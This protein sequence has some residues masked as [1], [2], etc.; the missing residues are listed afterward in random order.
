MATAP[1]PRRS[2][3][4]K[5]PRYLPVLELPP[6]PPEQHE[7]LRGNIAL[8]G[9]LVPILV[10]GEGPVRGIID[11]NLRH[12]IAAELG[13]DCPEVVKDGL[14]DQEK[15]T[16]ARALHLARRH[17]DQAGKRAIIADQ[18]R[19]T[20]GRS[21]RWVGKQL[22]VHHATVASVRADLEGTGQ[23]IQLERTVGADGKCRPASRP[24]GQDGEPL[25][26]D[27]PAEP[28]CLLRDGIM[29]SIDGLD[30]E[31]IIR[32]AAEIHRRRATPLDLSAGDARPE[33]KPFFRFSMDRA[34][35][36]ASN[37]RT[38][39]G[40]ARFLH[41]LISPLYSVEVILDPC[42][43]DASL[44]K[45]WKGRTVVDY[46]IERGKDFFD[47]P[48]RI[49][50]DLVLCNPPFNQEPESPSVYR[51][52]QF[53]RR[54]VS[55]VSP[56][57]PI[58][59]IAPMGMRLN[60]NKGSKRWRWLRDGAPSITSIVSLPRDVFSGVDFHCEV[61]LFNMPRLRSHY[62]LPDEYL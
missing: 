13:Y 29:T 19:E 1:R 11:G 44:T 5:S 30:E 33:P 38:P 18:L 61:L 43:G 9:V 54:I 51:P 25:T 41:D 6:L 12:R 50:C 35:P 15:R 17:L 45:P 46:E 2:R 34:R 23:I 4:R 16:L 37:Q 48:P 32:A 39:P 57:K 58:A 60:Q 40:V 26:F 49:E 14:S 21:N 52:E 42:A 36:R 3:T 53:L 8:H 22:G 24:P 10:D 7:A 28:H 27:E 47:C 62:F 31:E 56:G 20:P 59:L 55:V